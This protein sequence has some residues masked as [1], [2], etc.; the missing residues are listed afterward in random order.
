[1]S[2]S[3]P[4]PTSLGSCISCQEAEGGDLA[5]SFQGSVTIEDVGN[6]QTVLREALASEKN[7]V[8]HGDSIE[9]VDTAVMQLLCSFVNEV[10]RMS[11]AVSWGS[12][13]EALNQVAAWLGV[14][15][16]VGLGQAKFAHRQG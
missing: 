16:I 15:D 6:I 8:M 5:V 10:Q 12:A 3:V 14:T 4:N 2:D 11:R 9:K 13:S 1:M 7:I